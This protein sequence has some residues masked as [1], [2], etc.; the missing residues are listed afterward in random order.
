MSESH[1]MLTRYLLGELSEA[2][3]QALEESYF[4]DPRVFDEL[5]SAEDELVDAYVRDQLAP[6]LRQHFEQVYLT[7]PRRR[8]RVRFAEALAARLDGA[9]A[10]QQPQR[11]MVA[12]DSWWRRWLHALGHQPP[13]LGWA[14]ACVL[15]LSIAGGGL[16]LVSRSLRS[17]PERA[18]AEAVVPGERPPDSSAPSPPGITSPTRPAEQPPTDPGPTPPERVRP[19]FVT[20][21]LAVG[22]GVR[23]G[24]VGPPA[25]LIL[26]PE[27]SDVRLQLMLQEH[28]YS[29]YGV[30][31]DVVG[32]PEVFRRSSLRPTSGTSNATLTL[33]VPARR[34]DTG[35]Y[36][37]TL[38]GMTSSGEVE[39]VSQSLVHVEKR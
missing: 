12:T 27:T 24:D 26:T 35:D 13:A 16:W 34:F 25:R 36:V 19:R 18:Q 30:R 7:D 10:A 39:D 6:P 32:G 33:V 23:S 29:S 15:L 38:E 8:E 37:L 17:E 11:A 1:Q 2:E 21:A 14:L 3:R 28:E 20:L 4:A 5:A 31:I 22:P 9:V